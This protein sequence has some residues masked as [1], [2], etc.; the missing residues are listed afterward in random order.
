LAD[1]SYDIVLV[2]RDKARLDEV[3]EELHASYGVN[4]ESISADLADRDQVLRVAGRLSDPERP[5]D[6]LINN[7]GF[8]VHSRLLD[9]DLSRHELGID[10]MIRAVLTLANA[11][12][13]TMRDRQP[14]PGQKLGIINISSFAGYISMGSYSSIKSWVTTFSEGLAGELHGT[15]VQVTAV[16]P[17]WV[18]TEFHAR[19]GINASKIPSALWLEAD[20][21]VRG[22]L[23][24]FEHGRVISMPTV[25]YRVL[26]Q[27]VKHAPRGWIRAVSR[28]MASSRHSE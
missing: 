14:E 18:R 23:D 1:K 27:L 20:D 26:F 28:M 5:V 15:G 10:V 4:V 8:G 9:A 3:A 22:A 19:A 21:L 7:A 13:R 17:G 12:G 6:L 16:C 25:R 11:A 24:D 2:A